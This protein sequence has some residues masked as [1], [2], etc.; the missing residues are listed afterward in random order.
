MSFTPAGRL[1]SNDRDAL[2]EATL[3]GLGL[4]AFL[5]LHV[6]DAIRGRRLEVVL[7]DHE[8]PGRPIYALYTRD[9]ARLPKVRVFLSFLEECFG[10]PGAASAPSPR[11]VASVRSKQ[12][13]NDAGR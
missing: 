8:M 5:A 9:K 10:G 3:K 13:A 11:V 1:L 7:A 2:V 12:S 6:S 4:S